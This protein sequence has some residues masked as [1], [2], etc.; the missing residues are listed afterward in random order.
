M[1]SIVLFLPRQGYYDFLVKE[2]PLGLLS[3][4]RFLHGKYKVVII[5]QRVKGWKKNLELAVKTKPL[6]FGVTC[7]C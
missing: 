2:I 7:T 5:D 3:I 1:K 4:S 6:C